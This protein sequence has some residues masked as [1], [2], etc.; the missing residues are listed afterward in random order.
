MQNRP[1]P[2]RYSDQTIRRLL[3]NWPGASSQERIRATFSME[4]LYSH[5]PPYTV[6]PSEPTASLERVP[7]VMNPRFC[8]LLLMVIE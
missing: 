4:F 6:H 1:L 5:Y 2:R 7:H 8:L 3:H